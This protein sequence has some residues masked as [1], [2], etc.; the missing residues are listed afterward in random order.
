MNRIVAADQLSEQVVRLRVEAPRIARKRK[1]GQFVLVRMDE[2]AERVPLTIADADPEAGTI[3]LI[4]QVAGHSTLHL[5][6]LKAHD[7]IRDVVGPLGHPTHI[8][9]FGTAVPV[10]GGIGTAVV[11]PI[12]R[13]LRDAGNHVIGIIGARTKELVVLEEEMRSVSD[14]L[15]AATDD[16]SYGYHGFV[17]Q[18]LQGLIDE[19]RQIDFVAAVG[20]V[21]MMRA[22]CNVTR[23]HGIKTIVSLNPI[24]MDGTGMCGGC[25]VS[26]GGETKFACVDGPEF[27]GHQVDFDEL[28]KRQSMYIPVEREAFECLLEQ[29]VPQA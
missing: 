15:I 17:T 6:R 27:D 16:G 23:P 2:H 28:V 26:V 14:E 20:P 11:Y 3:T 19:G 24:M 10:G 12:A 21:P 8:E 25:R 9:N 29:V 5:S 1:P 7:A 18:A 22:T 13:A 4:I